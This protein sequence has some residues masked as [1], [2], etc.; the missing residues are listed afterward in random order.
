MGKLNKF[1]IGDTDMEM[2]IA[3][4]KSMMVVDGKMARRTLVIANRINNEPMA[5]MKASMIALLKEKMKNGV[6]HFIFT[7]KDGTLR[8]AWGTI[9]NKLMS[10]KIEG[11]GIPREQVNCI[12]YWDVE[13]GAF[14]SLR[15]ETLVKVF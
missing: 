13:K 5:L 2:V 6:A 10:D 9:S 12:A 11:T 3:N 15:F 7:K 14:R 4:N 8:E 1:S